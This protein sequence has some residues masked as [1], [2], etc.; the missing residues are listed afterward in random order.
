[1]AETVT[2]QLFSSHTWNVIRDSRRQIK[3]RTQQ[4]VIGNIW[5][6][7]HRKSIVAFLTLIRRDTHLQQRRSR[8]LSWHQRPLTAAS[9][10]RLPIDWGPS[11]WLGCWWLLVGHCQSARKLYQDKKNPHRAMPMLLLSQMQKRQPWNAIWA[12]SDAYWLPSSM[13]GFAGVPQSPAF[14]LASR[15]QRAHSKV[16]PEECMGQG[17]CVRDYIKSCV[18]TR[19]KYIAGLSTILQATWDLSL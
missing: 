11:L 15:G 13:L 17:A 9:I 19:L 12:Q 8:E 6:A 10:G 7:L 18:D 2:T 16:L 4:L 1:M 3:H 14:M 5:S